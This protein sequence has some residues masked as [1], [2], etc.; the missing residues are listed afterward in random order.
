[1]MCQLTLKYLKS[2]VCFGC[3]P[4]GS[5]ASFKINSG[6]VGL[7]EASNAGSQNLDKSAVGVQI[8]VTRA[9]SARVVALQQLKKRMLHSSSNKI[10]PL[11]QGASVFKR[12]TDLQIANAW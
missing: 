5:T 8:D 1:M 2:V 7:L 12:H 9:D 6:V 3:Q 10:V 11:P 4:T